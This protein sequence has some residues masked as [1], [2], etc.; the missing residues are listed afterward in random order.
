MPNYRH[1]NI[2]KITKEDSLPFQQEMQDISIV[3]LHLHQK[4]E[5]L[6]RAKQTEKQKSEG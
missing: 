5:L 4:H 2:I 1:N 3:R 6:M